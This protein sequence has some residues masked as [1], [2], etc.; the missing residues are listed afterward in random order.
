MTPLPHAPA[1]RA[2]LSGELAERAWCALEALAIGLRDAPE[3][4]SHGSLACGDAGIALFFAYLERARPGLGYDELARGRLER[5]AAWLTEQPVS[6]HLHS[7]AAGVAWVVAH[8]SDAT[9]APPDDDG[10]AE[11]D[12]LVERH[13]ELYAAEAPDFVGGLAGLAFY[14]LTRWPRTSARRALAALVERFEASA[15][16]RDDGLCWPVRATSEH[17]AAYPPGSVDLGVAH[18]LAGVASLLAQIAARAGSATAARLAERAFGWLRSL[19]R[20]EGPSAL[21]DVLIPGRTLAPARAAWCYGDPGTAGAWQTAA[22]ALGRLD[23]RH[24]AGALALRAA[25]RSAPS[26]GVRDASLCHGAVGLGLIFQRLSQ[27]LDGEDLA[28]AA[29]VWYARAL[30]FPPSDDPSLL[31]GAAGVGLGLLA[32]LGAGE[33]SW[34][35][36][37]LLSPLAAR[38]AA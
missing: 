15:E 14:A 36:L 25:R 31:T 32:A 24:E 29:A 35:A 2:A 11:I 22:L 27:Q 13:V 4:D 18:G 8:L 17:P 26:A 6:A 23:W 5:A 34:D 33:P 38:P 28:R 9:G 19:I 3:G 30:D 21:P 7:G 37:F 16:P 1:W 20:A 10:L 12:A